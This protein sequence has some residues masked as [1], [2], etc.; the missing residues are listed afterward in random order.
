MLQLQPEKNSLPAI[1][2][3]LLPQKVDGRLP[4][5]RIII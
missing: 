1:D 5:P 4:L 3:M 2:F